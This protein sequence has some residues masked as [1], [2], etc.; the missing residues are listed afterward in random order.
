MLKH[1]SDPSAL[2][3]SLPP[4]L[5]LQ[6]Y[7]LLWAALTD[8]REAGLPPARALTKLSDFF[9]ASRAAASSSVGEGGRERG[10]E[11]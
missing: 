3:P 10:K 5:T 4:S 2:P 8:Q 7:S 9:T 1:D 11:G 6:A